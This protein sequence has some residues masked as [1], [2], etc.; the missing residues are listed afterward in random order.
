MQGIDISYLAGFFDGEGCILF[1]ATFA[2]KLAVTQVN[3]EPLLLL[4]HA[5]GGTIIKRPVRN[6]RPWFVWQLTGRATVTKALQ[7]LL[8][9]LTVKRREARMM[10]RGLR[11]LQP[12]TRGRGNL[13]SP[14]TRK[15]R[16]WY[17]DALKRL[18]RV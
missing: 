9:H 14:L 11:E 15:R 2:P 17:I 3:P 12:A 6:G 4:G 10:L 1:T 18:K 16:Q 7:S 8:P 5:L 13:M